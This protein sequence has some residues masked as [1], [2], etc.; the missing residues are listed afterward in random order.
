MRAE[1]YEATDAHSL[2]DIM[3]AAEHLVAILQNHEE[4]TPQEGLE[5]FRLC[6]QDIEARFSGYRGITAAFDEQSVR[7]ASE[8]ALMTR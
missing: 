7:V 8:Q 6:L 5:R 1:T 3:D 4:L 2:A